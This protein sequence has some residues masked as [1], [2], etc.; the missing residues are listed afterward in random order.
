MQSQSTSRNGIMVAPM[1]MV[2]FGLL[3][4]G[5]SAK[6]GSDGRECSNA[7]LHGEYASAV[8]GVILPGPGV[9]L[10]LIG[11][12]M[13]HYDGKG[14]FTQVDH[15]IVNGAPPS[16][17]WTPGAGTYH[18]NADCSGTAQILESTGGFVNLAIVV[19]REGKEVH[20]VVAAPFDGPAR[21]VSSIAKRAE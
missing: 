16:I 8:K 5:L 1:I 11:V 17:M 13:T 4:S 6:A 14:N 12:A 2:T 3:L 7:S 18:V 19:V 20:A 15:I 9:S 10:P 21:T